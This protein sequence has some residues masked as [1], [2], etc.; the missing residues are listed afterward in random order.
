MTRLSSV[1]RKCSAL[2]FCTCLV[3]GLSRLS[4]GSAGCEAEDC[5][6]DDREENETAEV[7]GEYGGKGMNTGSTFVTMLLPN[8]GGRSFKGLD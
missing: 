3:T 1:E 8:R 7:G 6:S 5:E 2:P 4:V